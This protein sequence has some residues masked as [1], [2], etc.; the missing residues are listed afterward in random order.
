MPPTD[1][2]DLDSTGE[3]TIVDLA[4]R[5]LGP[6]MAL[7]RYRYLYAR[8]PLPAQCH[9]SLVVLVLPVKGTFEFYLDDLPRRV[10][11]GSV[12]RIR[13]RVTYLTG[14][15]GQ[16]RGDLT[17]LIAR[18]A[19]HAVDPVGRAVHLLADADGPLTWPAPVETAHALR[20]AFELGTAD[21]TWI[22]DAQLGHVLSDAVL[23][24]AEAMLSAPE[25]AAPTHPDVAR[26]L[27]WLEEH[28]T[29]PIEAADLA[30]VSGLSMGHFY[31]AF[32]A[33]TGTSPKDYLLRRKTDRARAWLES[34]PALTVTEVAH[35]L[36][37]PSS[38]SFATV[39]RRYQHR[40]PSA[41][42]SD[43]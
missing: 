8:E 12:L 25:P 35:R 28:L 22:T 4:D 29:E 15:T 42:R 38:Q 6:L 18:T 30:A 36:G 2:L 9:G 41:V 3:R 39:F 31:E 13:P 10:G 17:W 27:A 24:L 19:G 23:G 16:P 14:S 20:R 34:D 11:P 37:F 40:A 43:P 26:T 21:R 1:V 33:V 32:R 5:G 7:G